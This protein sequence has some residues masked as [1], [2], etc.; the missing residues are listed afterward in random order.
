[1]IYGGLKHLGLWLTRSLNMK[2]P[3]ST[4]RMDHDTSRTC[5]RRLSMESLSMVD[6]SVA[7]KGTAFEQKAVEHTTRKAVHFTCIVVTCMMCS[8]SVWSCDFSLSVFSQ[9]VTQPSKHR[10]SFPWLTRFKKGTILAAKTVETQ[11]RGSVSRRKQYSPDVV[12]AALD[13]LLP[14]EPARR[15]SRPPAG[16]HNRTS[17]AHRRRRPLEMVFFFY[18]ADIR[19]ACAT[20]EL[21]ALVRFVLTAAPHAKASVFGRMAAEAQG[22]AVSLTNVVCSLLELLLH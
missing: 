21:Q 10:T 14:E 6:C 2:W 5:S 1:M 13:L 18:R 7:R 12:Q 17:I 22:K 9:E 8:L 4:R 11:G 16:A 15:R 3:Q 19:L 20:S